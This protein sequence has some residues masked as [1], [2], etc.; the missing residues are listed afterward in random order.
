MYIEKPKRQDYTDNN[1]RINK[2]QDFCLVGL[3]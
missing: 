1:K 3:H 2:Q